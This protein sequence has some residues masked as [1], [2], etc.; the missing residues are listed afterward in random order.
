[1]ERGQEVGAGSEVYHHTPSG[2]VQLP[3]TLRA[4]GYG[5]RCFTK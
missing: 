4:N 5:N 3:A 1:M 2:F